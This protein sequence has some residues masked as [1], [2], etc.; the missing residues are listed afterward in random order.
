MTV[1]P[2]TRGASGPNAAGAPPR[3]HAGVDEQGLPRGQP[4]DR[5]RGGRDVIDARRQRRE[6]ARL[7][8][9]VLGQ[10]PVPRPVGQPDGLDGAVRRDLAEQLGDV[11]AAR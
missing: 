7:H 10:R 8:R 5:R 3:D 1:L 4:G 2:A 11:L 9:G 6:V